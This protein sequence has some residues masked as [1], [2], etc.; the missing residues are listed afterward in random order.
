MNILKV[1]SL[2]TFLLF[3]SCAPLE[4]EADRAWEED[5]IQNPRN[6]MEEIGQLHNEGLDYVIHY[7]G[8]IN[9]AD[10]TQTE[11]RIIELSLKFAAQYPEYQTN[12]KKE[13]LENA[14]HEPY[15]NMDYLSPNGQNL[16]RELDIQM[17]KFKPQMDIINFQREIIAL[18]NKILNQA[19]AEDRK[20]LLQSGAIARYSSVY[21][22]RHFK[23]IIDAN[24]T[25]TA[26][27]WQRS[28]KL[29]YPTENK[30]VI[31]NASQRDI[32]GRNLAESICLSALP[33]R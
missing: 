3:N 7:L 29:L 23:R 18:E 26:S 2:I 16:F 28:L 14:I 30:E 21:W 33:A 4:Y 25:W 5:I 8:T 32:R 22:H 24:Y 15:P 31:Y 19:D 20:K 12:T 17:S 1:L 10:P 6:P 27:D 13:D 9:S 11:E